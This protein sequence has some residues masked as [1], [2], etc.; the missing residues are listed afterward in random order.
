MKRNRS[1]Y[2]F[3]YNRRTAVLFVLFFIG[4]VFNNT[5]LAK[6]STLVLKNADFNRNTLERGSLVS[7][8]Q[9][10]VVFVYENTTICSDEAIWY[11]GSGVANFKGNVKLTQENQELTCKRL[12][13][14]RDEKKLTAQDNIDFFDKK[15]SMRII[16]QKGVYYF[17]K[18][19]L[20][21]TKN[22]QMFQYD[23]TRAETLS[24]AGDKMVYND[25]LNIAT[26][27][28]NVVIT[29]G[30]LRSRCKTATCNM[31]TDVAKL[32]TDPWIYYDI[33]EVTGD[34]VDLFFVDEALK[35]VSVMRNAKG[36]HRDITLKDTIHTNVTGDSIYMA[37]SDSGTVET[38][39][40][41]KDAHTVY[42]SSKTPHLQNEGNGKFMVLHFVKG[43]T[44]TMNIS[45]NAECVYYLNEEKESGKNE[46]NG[47]DIFIHF[48]EGKAV[49]I[50]LVGG[51]RGTYF[52][53]RSK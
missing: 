37:I 40:T 26:A 32:R 29:K 45:G 39:W 13:F 35:G 27:E 11:R 49:H 30:L 48:V 2:Q 38:I 1:N 25:S 36:F 23:T 34:S 52:A 8:L 41:H 16:A 14:V 6:N 44:G 28:N 33:H 12:D 51:V 18:K 4:I 22:P 21:L 24:I 15:K 46:A 42:Y 19:H 50:K 31:E 17:E 53:E 20:T 3:L 7:V 5:V 47:D 10:N 9:G 43:T